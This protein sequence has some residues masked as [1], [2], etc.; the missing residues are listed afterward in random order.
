[1]EAIDLSVVRAINGAR[2]EE[3]GPVRRS[4]SA[5]QQVSRGPGAA[6]EPDVRDLRVSLPQLRP[7]RAFGHQDRVG[8][9]ILDVGQAPGAVDREAPPVMTRLVTRAAGGSIRPLRARSAWRKPMP[10]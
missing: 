8:G 10:A 9:A 7:P 2:P 5:P 4:A 3:G 1:V 6:A